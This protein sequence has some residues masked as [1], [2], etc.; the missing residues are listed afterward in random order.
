MISNGTFLED[1]PPKGCIAFPSLFREEEI[2]R[3]DI[4]RLTA[5]VVS[6]A[7]L[8]AAGALGSAIT[9]AAQ[10]V[11]D[12]QMPNG[13]LV[14][15]S[16]GSFF[17]GGEEVHQTATEIGGAFGD[18]TIVVN[19]MYVEYMIPQGGGNKVPVVMVHGGTLSGK[20]FETTPDGR[21]GWEEYFVRQGYPVYNADQVS[22]ARSGFNQAV[23]NNVRAG[24]TPPGDQPNM[25]RIP[26][27]TAW[28]FFRF[29]PTPGVP[30]PDTQFPVEAADEFGKQG[31]PDLN[32]SLPDPNPIYAA[33]S[34]LAIK[35][36]GAVL[37]GHSESSAF[38]LR[39]ILN[40]PT[41]IRAAIFLETTFPSRCIQFT[42][43]EKEILAT[44]PILFVYG[45]HLDQQ[46]AGVLA[47]FN[48]CNALVDELN[49]LGGNATMLWPPD[50]GI[51]GNTHM[52][53]LDKNNL[54]IA[55]L[56]MEWIDE[57]VGKQKK[58]AKH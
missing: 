57:N 22:R 58:M 12:L 41:G 53:M 26:N 2:M 34:D 10:D 55:D 19:Q 36:D 23:Y 14:L 56:I 48:N 28:T 17:V 37:M 33:L 46:P 11:S 43:E 6:T 16:T 50:L 21:M 52:F 1:F 51:Y 24:I 47:A 45:D 31:I 32:S 4:L 40:D 49:A 8:F 38:P 15:K 42:Q 54:Q 44:V 9:A 18:G 27:E 7:F 39:A 25:L 29:G 5:C 3:K 35:L 20:S 13:S 30:W